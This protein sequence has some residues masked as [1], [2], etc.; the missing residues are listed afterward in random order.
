MCHHPHSN[1]TTQTSPNTPSPPNCMLLLPS[2]ITPN[3]EQFRLRL[4]EP[5]PRMS[6]THQK[7]E[8]APRKQG[9]RHHLSML[10]TN[11]KGEVHHRSLSSSPMQQQT[12]ALT[13][14]SWNM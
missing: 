4:Y 3:N 5:R 6:P 12:A 1:Q 10:G 8:A 9:R 11:T 14:Y 7:Q 2:I 13:S